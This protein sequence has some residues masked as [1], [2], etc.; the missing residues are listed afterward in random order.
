MYNAQITYN[1]IK[2]TAKSKGISISKINELC[3]LSENAISNAA[4][5]EFGMKAKNIVLIAEILDVSTD[6]LLGKTDIPN[7]QSNEINTNKNIH[8]IGSITQTAVIG[9]NSLTTDEMGTELLNRFNNMSFADKMD[10]MN[11]VLNKNKG[12]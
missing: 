12:E 11:Y 6:Y 4:K 5:S 10:I 3:S 1:R 8:N 9:S 7:L 2:E